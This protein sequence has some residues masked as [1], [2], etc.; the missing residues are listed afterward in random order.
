MYPPFFFSFGA[1]LCIADLL[2]KTDSTVTCVPCISELLSLRN[3]RFGRYY[4]V[5]VEICVLSE[6]HTSKTRFQQM[7]ENLRLNVYTHMLCEPV[8]KI[9]YPWLHKQLRKVCP[10]TS[11]FF[12]FWCESVFTCNRNLSNNLLSSF[13]RLILDGA[14]CLA[15]FFLIHGMRLKR[16]NTNEQV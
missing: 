7:N 12:K 1:M 11:R 2:I 16:S 10:R 15:N 14:I 5:L 6:I 9:S 4:T 13:L 8:E 3:F